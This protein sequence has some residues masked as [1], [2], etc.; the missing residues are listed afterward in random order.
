MN[1]GKT[2][3]LWSLSITE[4][5]KKTKI[6]TNVSRKVDLL[7]FSSHF[8][9]LN[10]TRIPIFR[11][12]VSVFLSAISSFVS[13]VFWTDDTNCHT[14]RTKKDRFFYC[15]SVQVGRLAFVS[16]ILLV[17]KVIL[18]N[19]YKHTNSGHKHAR[20]TEREKEK[21]I[22]SEYLLFTPEKS[23]LTIPTNGN[24]LK[25]TATKTS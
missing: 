3:Q 14:F 17:L 9:L 12:L 24:L 7:S 2:T 1:S 25:T 10:L 20:K 23:R 5:N 8:V 11:L 16:Y 15:I 6:N 18:F 22:T 4:T 19:V 13:S 21:T